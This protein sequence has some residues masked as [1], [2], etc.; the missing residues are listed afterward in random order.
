MRGR[1]GG[2]AASVT[3]SP[4]AAV[5]ATSSKAVAVAAAVAVVAALAVVAVGAAGCKKQA[6][7]GGG[8]GARATSPLP[9]V[10]RR[11]A[12]ELASPKAALHLLPPGTKS[13]IGLTVRGHAESPL[14]IAMA[15]GLRARSGAD[16]AAVACMPSPLEQ[17]DW[18]MLGDAREGRVMVLRGA[19]GVL[20]GDFG[21]CVARALGL[22]TQIGQLWTDAGVRALYVSERGV[23]VLGPRAWVEQLAR[24]PVDAQ[25]ASAASAPGLDG[26]VGNALSIKE[27]VGRVEVERGFWVVLGDAGSLPARGLWGALTL[28]ALAIEGEF[29]IEFEDTSRAQTFAGMLPMLKQQPQA[30]EMFTTLE[31]VVTGSQL[32]VTMSSLGPQLK[33]FVAQAEKAGFKL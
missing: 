33:A 17:L 21:G 12:E 14:L 19:G 32:T 20:P 15:A 11:P 5:A 10:T 28:S 29:M 3:A 30:V 6:R 25:R 24:S 8:S 27:L 16:G 1:L 9:S 2:G 26:G 18:L 31:G 4:S 23:A 7:R 13:I 22:G